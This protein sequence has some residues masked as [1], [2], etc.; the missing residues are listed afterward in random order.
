MN[1]PT[2]QQTEEY[3]EDFHVPDNF[4]NHCF[5]VNKVAVFLGEELKAKG[6]PLDLDLIDRLS[7]MHDLFKPITIKDLGP[8]PKYN[9][10]PT[11]N[12]VEFWK[13][14]QQRYPSK[15][16]TQVFHD[17]FFPEFPELAELM[18]HY[19]NHD[20][21]TSKK[22]REE[23]I[24]HY[25]DW[26]VF[27]DTI[28]PLKE[29]MDDLFKRYNHKIMARHNGKEVWEKRMADEIAVE[30]SIF[31]KIKMKPENVKKCVGG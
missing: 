5:I 17:I 9:C 25:A 21:M 1:L 4:K 10:N 28:I 8:D 11:R 18:L 29:R 20:I 22:S 3:F 19:G 27:C 6:E 23:Q 13:E 2:R 14:M 15:H 26:R 30:K 16:E 24:V 12:Q 31:D 7:L